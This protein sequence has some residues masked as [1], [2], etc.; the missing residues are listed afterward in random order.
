MHSQ[1]MASLPHPAL[2]RVLQGIEAGDPLVE[3]QRALEQLGKA[4]PQAALDRGPDLTADRLPA[5]AVLRR[6]RLLARH[7][8]GMHRFLHQE[9]RS[10]E[11]T[12][13]LQSLMRIS[14]AV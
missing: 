8:A 11:H 9:P 10:D 3:P 1:P 5:Q 2:R 12:S 7:L 6:P 14:Y 4:R 13:E